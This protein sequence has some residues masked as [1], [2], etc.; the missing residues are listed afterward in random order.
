MVHHHAK[1]YHNLVVLFKRLIVKIRERNPI[2]V[3][4]RTYEV[5][6]AE[7]YTKLSKTDLNA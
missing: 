4:L 3:L 5:L 2:A 7:Y 6:A 1:S